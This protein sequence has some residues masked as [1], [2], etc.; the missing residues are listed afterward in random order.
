MKLIKANL[1]SDVTGSYDQTKTTIQGNASQ[2]TFSGN[3]YLGPPLTKFVD[4]FTDTGGL[5]TPA[6]AVFKS[7]N[8][9]I[10]ILG[11]TA[12]GV[13]RIALYNYDSL[14][15][16][17]T[18]VGILAYNLPNTAATTHTIRGFKVIDTGTTGWKIFI[19]T[20]ASV[21]I[22]G[23]T[24]LLNKIDLVD[25]V[26]VPITPV[27]FASGNDQ[28]AVYFLQETSQV[29]VNHLN[30]SSA[31]SIYQ[32]T[33]NYL[34]IQNGISATYQFYIYDTSIAPTYSNVSSLVI[35]SATDT[36]TDVGHTYNN[37]D[38]ILLSNLSGGA[39]LVNNTV[40]FVRN[41]TATTYQLSGTSGGVI[42]N[43]TT[44]GTA[45]IG[46]AFGTTVSNFVHKT[47]NLPAL[48]GTLLLTDSADFA[49]P[50]HTANAGFDCAF[51]ATSS[52]LYLGKLS[53]LT[54]GTTSWSSLLTSNILGT[55]NQFTAPTATFASWSNTLDSVFYVTNVSKFIQKKIVNNS[56]EHIFGE[57]N[58]TYY[59]GFS[60]PEATSVGLV[61]IG[62]LTMSN[63]VMIVTGT[64]VGQRGFFTAD[65]RSDSSY[66]YS[67]VITPVLDTPNS[68]L[69]ITTSVETFFDVTGNIKI[70]YRDSGFGSL[71]GGWIDLPSFA[72]L[73]LYAIGNQIQF[74][75]LFNMQSEESSSPAQVCELYIGTTEESEISDNWE[76]S[77]DFSD[78]GSPSRICFRLKKAYSSTV[79]TL[80]FRAFDLSNSPVV[81]TQNTVTN[82][83]NFEYSTDNGTIWNPL[84]TITNT[85]GTLLR[86]TFSSPPGVDVRPGIRES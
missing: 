61:T 59:E 51:F 84:G 41:P 5:V 71:S 54:P 12:A 37:N 82:S 26:P 50:A 47:G 73:N 79:P 53:E 63:G 14:S 48:V 8:D 56:V 78:N 75:I 1:L 13:G 66:D 57:L 31:G 22:N 33:T 76:F 10:F 3:D 23:G 55:T 38:P 16:V 85:V 34:Y 36:V 45:T 62:G 20:T 35:D 17:S 6:G 74:K 44:N 2:K 27:S 52:N 81:A 19:T 65:L 24:F 68:L 7:N 25:F 64:T 29:G 4:V 70:Q 46:R 21:T 80:Y 40:Y 30:I 60:L 49:I 42:I 77:D 72:N 9:R 39:G 28:K 43:I 11:T 32:P 67:Y 86:Y 69:E 83:A 18:Y 58:T 15:G